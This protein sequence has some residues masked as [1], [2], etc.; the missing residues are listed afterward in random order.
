M[1][2]DPVPRKWSIEEYLSHEEQTGVKHEYIDGAIYAM[3]GG[4]ESHSRITA[5]AMIALGQQLRD[6][7]CDINT[8]DLRIQISP[9]RFVYPD[10]SV[11]CGEAQ[12]ADER[13]TMLL[14]PVLVVEVMSPSTAAY[15]R[16]MKGE[17]YRSL[18]S[19]RG[20]L[21]LDQNRVYAQFFSRQE[22]GWLM[23]EFSDLE[24]SIPLTMIDATLPL[25]EVYRGI[26]FDT[27]S[28]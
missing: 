16:G 8:C 13:R 10:F 17:F 11:V 24:V 2:S 22:S 1:A 7:S 12:F 23:Q 19:L 5:N 14:N 18:S 26:R 21:L 9:T 3:S 15:D 25:R 4:T 28:S 6:A 20:Y 27:T